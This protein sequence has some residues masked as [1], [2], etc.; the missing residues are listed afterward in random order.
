M[1]STP[2]GALGEVVT[3]AGAA[4]SEAARQQPHGDHYAMVEVPDFCANVE[5]EIQLGLSYRGAAD[6]YRTMLKNEIDLGTSIVR[7]DATFDF[8]RSIKV[9]RKH[10]ARVEAPVAAVG[11][12]SLPGESVASAAAAVGDSSLPGESV[13]S[14]AL[15]ASTGVAASPCLSTSASPYLRRIAEV[16]SQAEDWAKCL[17][18]IFHKRITETVRHRVTNVLPCRHFNATRNS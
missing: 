12:S 9:R 14:L 17:K 1:A 16:E 6:V 10:M 8:S 3:A 18:F 13:A 7:C 15:P 5:R 4:R 11:D 2:V